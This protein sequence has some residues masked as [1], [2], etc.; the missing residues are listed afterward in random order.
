MRSSEPGGVDSRDADVARER[1]ARLFRFVAAVYERRNPAQR[2]VGDHEWM[3]RFS[4]IPET[5]SIRV[6]TQ[7]EISTAEE[8]PDAAED[9]VL[10][11]CRR[12]SYTS[13]PSP[14]D[15][16]AEWLGSD[17]TDCRNSPSPV[18]AR[19]ERVEDGTTRILHFADDA[20]RVEALE[21]YRTD[22][23]SWAA[24]ER[25]T[26]ASGDVFE[27]LYALRG[28]LERDGER[29]ELGAADG[30]LVWARKNG[31]VRHP[32][33]F[34]P[35]R[36]ECSPQV[37]EFRIVET[38]APTEFYSSLFRSMDDVDGSVIGRLRAD[39]EALD[40]HPLGGADVDGFLRGVATSLSPR[41]EYLGSR[42]PGPERDDPA[43]GRAPLF[44]LRRR[45]SGL[46]RAFDAVVEAALANGELPRALCNVV[47]KPMEA[48]ISLETAEADAG[49]SAAFDVNEDS[50]VLFTKPANA[51]QLDIARCLERNDCVL[52]QGPPGTGKTHRIANLL[53]HLL[54]HGK[55]VLVVSHTTKALKVLREKVVPELQPLCV[56]VLDSAEDDAAL[57]SSVEG[58]VGR[59][60]SA[61]A[62]LLERDIKRFE[63]EREALL[64]EVQDVRAAVLDARMHEVR[65][66]VVGGY[67][68]RPIEAAKEVAEGDDSHDWIPSPV[69]FGEP[70]PLT[71]GELLELYRTNE[72]VTVQDEDAL[73]L[74]L[75]DLGGVPT[76]DR[77][78]ELLTE[79]RAL[80]DAERDHRAD[81][82]D[83]GDST[84]DLNDAFAKVRSAVVL[85]DERPA[86][87]L[88]LVAEGSES[89]VS[90][91]T[92][93]ILFGE[94]EAV[95]NASVDAA[96][97]IAAYQPCTASFAGFDRCAEVYG[98][99]ANDVA[100]T[101]KPP[102]FVTLLAH[103]DWKVA[104]DGATVGGGRKPRLPE[105]F[106]ALAKVAS[107]AR[108]RDDLK[109]RWNAQ[110]AAIGGPAL[111]GETA[112]LENVF[113]RYRPLMQSALDWAEATW[114]PALGAL[115][116]V[117]FRWEACK[118]EADAR[119]A[120]HDQLERIRRV[121]V[122]VLPSAFA[123]EH[124]R[125]RWATV[126]SQ[127][128]A[129]EAKAA[130]WSDAGS[131]APLRSA[132]REKRPDAYREA[133]DN[134][135]RL[136]SL[137]ANLRARTDLLIRL[138]R[139]APGWAADIRARVGAHAGSKPPGDVAKAWRWRQFT[140]ELDRRN[141][142]SLPD[143]VSRLEERR[144]RL[145]E[146]TALLVDRRAWRAQVDRTTPD[147]RTALMSFVQAKKRIGRGTGKR[148]ATF[149]KMARESLTAARTAVPVWIM[150]VVKAA[151]M[152]DPRY[153]KFD[154]VIVDEASQ[155]DVTGLLAFFLGRQ[156]VVVGDDEQV[157]P[158]AVGEQ[159]EDAQH[160]IDEFLQGIPAA[161]LFDG[162]QSLYDI[163]KRAF[164]GTTR[165]LEHFR[166]VPDIIRFSNHL[167]YD[168]AIRPLRE[169]RPDLPSPSVVAHRVSSRGADGKVNEDE[170]RA[171]AA[172]AA[173]CIEQPE[174]IGKTFGV[175]SLVGEDQ[176]R[177]VEQILRGLLP[178]DEI[179]ARRLL[180]GNASQ[181][182]GDERH[183]MFLS[184]VHTGAGLPLPIVQERRRPATFQCRGQ[185]SP[186]SDVGRLFA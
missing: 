150:P 50:D 164:G 40:P 171:V 180:A 94:V 38:G 47:G 153:A 17:W 172:L 7:A 66:V 126:E 100:R 86:W 155:S 41:G 130:C 57:K 145:R 99:I 82:W 115:S 51:E 111:D 103:R 148:A 185:P 154:V 174:Y 90:R 63:A 170:A 152:F 139:V 113:A 14:P 28:T 25:V 161:Q 102:G 68:I 127:L 81:L 44:L 56:S 69:L 9:A 158:S 177:R 88:R 125:R 186:G 30:M 165:L 23:D 73:R 144:D 159:V 72:N 107:L 184:A 39:A 96:E 129:A 109:R 46:A 160:L 1:I 29:Y 142:V 67:G 78:T 52:V 5:D 162:K 163:A 182:Q 87:T 112:D 173:A 140:D 74:T 98:A 64:R 70:L 179:E 169:A 92:W 106:D 121:V 12:P 36:L 62:H 49:R 33:L 59:L 151:E 54:A 45:T 108:K 24:T 120:E 101:G 79:R 85:L 11:R 117:G 143:I 134:V 83:G 124:A 76:P 110:V 149:A 77:F 132:L 119:Y 136:R 34:R 60:G 18:E 61:D 156:I 4:D 167:S 6:V 118:A 19:N 80:V 35:A 3:L 65:E 168:G 176:A 181:F 16:L 20:I 8:E 166:C 58:I 135:N 137:S 123:A 26:V 91:R 53:G 146:A 31:D 138:E 131:A 116:S 48:L 97:I 27:R 104:I 71:A 147:Q 37:P 128:S 157:S 89:P 122:E 183:I 133:Y 43:I 21:V 75:P 93:E 84:A 2:Q 22:W 178:P 114:S 175:I 10:L 141:R 42:P 55:S 95:G 105:H 32:L 15:V 13:P